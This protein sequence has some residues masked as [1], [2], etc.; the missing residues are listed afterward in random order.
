MQLLRIAAGP[1]VSKLCVCPGWRVV[2]ELEQPQMLPFP[3]RGDFSA[4]VMR[5]GCQGRSRVA[6]SA[7]GSSL[8]SA[9]ARGTI[10]SYRGRVAHRTL[11]GWRLWRT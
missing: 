3:D 2:G 4:R 11:V 10:S 9:P 8:D 6:G 5:V 7:L 1:A